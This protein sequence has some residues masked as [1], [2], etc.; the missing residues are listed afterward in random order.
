VVRAT[1]LC[2]TP[3]WSPNQGFFGTVAVRETTVSVRETQIHKTRDI[4]GEED[5]E[6]NDTF[7]LYA[8]VDIWIINI[9]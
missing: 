2:K 3:I 1:G 5:P 7:Q 6:W 8:S 4:V 9:S